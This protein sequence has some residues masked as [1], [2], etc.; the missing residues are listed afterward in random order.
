MGPPQRRE[1]RGG[2][3]DHFLALAER[4]AD[5]RA[6]A[7]GVAAEHRGGI[8]TTLARSGSSRQNLTP[9]SQPSG[10]TSALAKYSGRAQDVAPARSSPSRRAV[11]LR[12]ELGGERAPCSSAIAS[13]AAAACWTEGTA[14]ETN[15]SPLLDSN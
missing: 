8:A 13:A 1:T 5:E 2:L 14:T 15:L 11:A 3:V 9:S 10:R 4:E 6:G 7:L 12:L